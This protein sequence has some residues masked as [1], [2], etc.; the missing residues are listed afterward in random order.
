M[1]ARHLAYTTDLTDAEWQILA[2]FLPPD[3]AGG[4]PRQSPLREVINGLQDIRRG[5]C[6]WRLLP[7]ALPHGQTA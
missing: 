3:R 6:A 7:H 5:G 2:P 1:A 4:R